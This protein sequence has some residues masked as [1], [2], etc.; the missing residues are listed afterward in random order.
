[1]T[2]PDALP[3]WGIK[4]WIAVVGAV[5]LV[6][7]AMASSAV[8][9]FQVGT[10]SKQMDTIQSK[11]MATDI[12]VEGR[13]ATVQTKIEDIDT[14]TSRIEDSLGR[15]ESAVGSSQEIGAIQRSKRGRP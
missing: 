6:G 7:G 13:L 5:L 14:R 9:R 15:I 2:R 11:K 8:T 12:S 1:M 3:V 4:T 10:L